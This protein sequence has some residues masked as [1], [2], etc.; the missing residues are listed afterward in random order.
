MEGK[1]LVGGNEAI[2]WGALAAGCL[3]YFGYPITPQNEVVEFFARE[4]PPRG[5]CFVQSEAE[6]SSIALL[7]GGASTGVRAMTSTASPGW[8]LMQEGISCMANAELPCVIVDVQR[9]GPGQGTV[10]HSQMDYLSATRGGGHGGYKSIVL[11]PSSVQECHDLVQLAF[12]LADRYRNPVIVLSDGVLGRTMESLDRRTLEFGPLPPKDWAVRG[13]AQNGGARSVVVCAQGTADFPP[14]GVVLERLGNKWQAM[15]EEARFEAYRADDAELLLVAFGYV[16]RSCKE[17]VNMARAEGLKV[18]LLRPVTLWPFPCG[19]VGARARGGA[20]FLVVEDN[21]G[22]MVDDVRLGAE[23]QA[24]VHFLGALAR[25]VN[26]SLGML[27][28][29][30]V[31]EEVKRLL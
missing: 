8:S 27:M 2:G 21:L 14:Y 7:Y 18:G 13:S 16:A 3:H 28:P 4:L 26:T 12:Y 15:A 25:H 11:A 24:P 6:S 10:T 5:G 19:E 20:R 22:Q 29:E 23:G 31:L 30:R 17:A 1:V 9:G